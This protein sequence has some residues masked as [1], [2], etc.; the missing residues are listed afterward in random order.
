MTRPTAAIHKLA[1][2]LCL[3]SFCSLGQAS[4]QTLVYPSI[5]GTST[6]DRSATPY[7]VEGDQVYKAIPGSWTIRQGEVRPNIP[8]TRTPKAP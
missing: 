7:V 4:E 8:G 1:L 3:A 5:P 6:P 2:T